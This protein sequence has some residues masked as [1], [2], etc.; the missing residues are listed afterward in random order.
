M[1]RKVPIKPTPEQRK[2]KNRKEKEHRQ[3]ARERR[4]AARAVEAV[5]GKRRG[6]GRPFGEVGGY[7]KPW[8]KRIIGDFYTDCDLI[9]D[10]ILLSPKERVRLITELDPKTIFEDSP[11]EAA[12]R[13][14]AALE[15]IEKTSAPRGE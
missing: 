15:E 12:A 8:M 4:A 3:E 11:E 6:P 14:R 13:I 1:P 7:F 2:E 9:R 5:T 10:V